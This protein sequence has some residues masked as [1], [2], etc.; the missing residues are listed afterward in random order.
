MNRRD[1]LKLFPALAAAPVLAKIPEERFYQSGSQFGKTL[2]IEDI[3]RAVDCL[4]RNDCKPLNGAYY[5]YVH[6][7]TYLD[8]KN[9]S[10]VKF[11][12][13]GHFEG[14]NFHETDS[15]LLY[16]EVQPKTVKNQNYLNLRG[17][18]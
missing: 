17:R 18:W 16:F 10:S 1:F 15:D 3:K 5:G 11:A 2:T 8:L 12:E 4:E 13:M 7:D 14:I 6:P 9:G